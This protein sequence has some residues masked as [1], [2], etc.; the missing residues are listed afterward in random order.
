[1]NLRGKTDGRQQFVVSL[2][3]P[4]VKAAH[5]WSVPQ[6]VIREAGKQR[7]TLLIVPEQG[8]R[9]QAATR[10]GLT[11]LD[12]QK[13]G[14]RQKGVLEFRILQTPWTLAL[15]VEQVEPWI[16]VTSLQH[17]TVNEA[18]VKVIA[19]LQYQIENTGLKSFRVLL[20]TNAESVRFTGDQVADFLAVDG[21]ITNGLQAWE[22]KLHRRVIGQYVPA[23]SPTRLRCPTGPLRRHCAV[24][25]PPR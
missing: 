23:C 16:Q 18:Q 12:P 2:S 1:M 19:N 10:D 22:I 13:S 14:V 9:L 21:A 8:M 5:G 20:P 3:G 11:Q 15:D 25:K 6:F 24:C 4:G 17:A 7:G